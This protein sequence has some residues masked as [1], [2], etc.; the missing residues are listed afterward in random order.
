MKITVNRKKLVT[1]LN[2]MWGVHVALKTYADTAFLTSVDTV[3]NAIINYDITDFVE[4]EE[5]G[6]LAID[7]ESFKRQVRSAV[8]DETLRIECDTLTV[9]ITGDTKSPNM[10]RQ[11]KADLL[12]VEFDDENCFVTARNSQFRDLFS[13]TV[14]AAD[15]KND[16]SQYTLEGVKLE[17]DDYT[18]TAVATDAIRMATANIPLEIVGDPFFP[19]GS[20]ILTTRDVKQ[21]VKV[22]PRQKKSQFKDPVYFHCD[23]TG[24]LFIKIGRITLRLQMK[25]VE[26]YPRWRSFFQP[27]EATAGVCQFRV[28]AGR[29]QSAIEQACG[30]VD[31]EEVCL[32]LGA[33]SVCV[34]TESGLAEVPLTQATSYKEGPNI[35]V[36]LN[37]KHL[38]EYLKAL[39]DSDTSVSI[40]VTNPDS[41]VQFTTGNHNYVLMPRTPP[42]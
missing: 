36:Y 5:P 1:A 23:N 16:V 26:R 8:G 10:V 29:L 41:P 3:G 30:V 14:F 2:K 33:A 31:C 32:S 40:N 6:D 27:V 28:V 12:R 19:D 11:H 35:K 4:I 37:P 34:K 13:Q 25:F 24:F 7:R 21:L 42:K 9:T 22:L 20:Y 38:L 39:I 18:L 17:C 15:A